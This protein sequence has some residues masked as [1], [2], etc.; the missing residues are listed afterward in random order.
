MEKGQK[1][2]HHLVMKEQ[3][4]NLSQ[5]SLEKVIDVW[6]NRV[7]NPLAQKKKSSLPIHGAFNEFQFG[8]LPLDL[9]I[10]DGPSEACFH[11]GFVFLYPSR[12][13]LK[14]CQVAGVNPL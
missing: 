5:D 12:K 3:E 14:L 11:S 10:V 1:S 6:L 9:A 13:L 4:T 7:E 8:D 2:L